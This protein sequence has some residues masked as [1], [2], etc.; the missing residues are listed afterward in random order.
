VPRPPAIAPHSALV[1]VRA[2]EPTRPA[3]ARFALSAGSIAGRSEPSAGG[4]GSATGPGTARAASEDPR[5]L[6]ESAVDVPARLATAEPPLYPEAAR[7]AGLELD[8]P[9]QLIVS[10]QGRVL[11][12]AALVHPGYGLEEAALTAVRS[13]LFLPARRAGRPVPVKMRWTM[14]FRLR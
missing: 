8:L 11:S 5:P 9:L 10:P 14:Q 6:G 7:R 12:A 3:L 1:P 13:Y 4:A 2:D